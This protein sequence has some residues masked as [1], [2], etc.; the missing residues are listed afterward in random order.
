MK[1]YR[2][3]HLV[4][5]GGIGLS[6]IARILLAQGYRVSGSDPAGGAITAALAAKGAQIYPS[7][8]A[9]NVTSDTDLVVITSAVGS[10]NPEVQAAQARGIRVVKRR[11]FL[12][13]LTAD[14]RTIAVAGS[15]G[16]TTTALVG[17]MLVR[18]GLDPNMIVG[19]IV[20]E[21][22]SNARAG[23]GQYFVI[24][25]DEYDNAFLGL[26]PYIAIITNVDYDHPDIFPTREEYID[27]FATFAKRVRPDGAVI[28]CGE[29]EGSR[30][31]IQAAR[32]G[33]VRYGFEPSDE[34]QAVEVEQNES[35][36]SDF[37]VVRR[38]ERLGRATLRIP[39]RHN[40]LNA[41][42][43]LA[44]ADFAG[45]PIET[46]KTVLGE[47]HGTG[48]R[49]E[50]RGEYG[51]VAIIDDYAHHPTEIRATLAAAR[52]RYPG[53]KIWAVFQPHTY[54]RTR[55]LLDEFAQAFDDADAVIVTEIYAAR[56]H[57]TL[58]MSGR[59]I[60]AR[61]DHPDVR[62][63]PSLD[64]VLDE[65]VR[66]VTPGAVVIT[67]GAGDVNRVGERLAVLRDEVSPLA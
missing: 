48:R 33:V 22:G 13:E 61:M 27:A 53:R 31:A 38:G 49:F 46:A 30:K 34:W 65:L 63:V 14:Y 26:E 67:L 55:A 29:E 1:E 66:R 7:H 44:A 10:D 6:A 5:I 19:G 17:L 42:A 18:A 21:L 54:S 32:A 8:R 40:V 56:E 57:D 3:V 62:F 41:L 59:D 60:V 28:I 37:Q 39:G 24:E 20:P 4:G 23:R 52:V 36:G 47:Y 64:Q 2:H 50:V 43:A 51:G 9:E 12:G 15:H 16:K 45:V 58:G 11:D 35:G 25:A